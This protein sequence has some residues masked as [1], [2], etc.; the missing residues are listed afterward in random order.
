M[1]PVQAGGKPATST[2]NTLVAESQSGAK[3]DGLKVGFSSFAAWMLGVGSIIG[4]MAWLIHGPML[5]RAGSLASITAWILAGLM[6]LPLALILMELSS[7]FPT[8]GGPYVYKFYALKRLVPGAGEMLGFLTGWLFWSALIVGLAC[9]ANGLSNLLSS[10]FYGS[11][12]ASPIWFGPVAIVTLFGLTTLLNLQNVKTAATISNSFTILKLL[13]AVG[14]ASLVLFTPGSSIENVISC[15][16]RSVTGNFWSQV[17]SVLMLAMAGFSFL[18]IAGCLSAETKDAKHSVPKAMFLTLLTVTFIYVGMCIAIC[19][20][21][22]LSISPDKTTLVIT[23]TNIQATCPAIAG[24][25]GGDLIGR[26]FT[27]AVVLSIVGCGFSGLMG[28]AR[29]SYSMAKTKLFPRQFAKID[30]RSGVPRYALWFQ[31]WCLVVV[32]TAANLLS[33]TN[34]F[35]DSYTFLAE[36]FGFM[37]AFVAML[38]GVCV[39]SLRYTDPAMERPFR[40][41]ASGNVLIWLVALETTAIWG[42]AAFCCVK[43]VHQAAGMLVLLAGLPIYFYYKWANRYSLQSLPELDEVSL[44]P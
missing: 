43:P 27:A 22:P 23:G 3:A 40:V 21:A 1:S 11:A 26:I 4:S 20:V 16:S 28:I 18:E 29:V 5:A 35:A 15:T 2:Q 8:A 6:S 41:G 17:A 44:H 24:F 32:A 12:S 37:Y 34:L 9:M 38:Y 39:V 13:M 10:A 7:M 14:F 31:F 19:A 25:I 42:Y 36:V 30:H 33:R